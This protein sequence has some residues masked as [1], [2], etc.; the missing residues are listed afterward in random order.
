MSK[1]SISWAGA[2]ATAVLLVGICAVAADWWI[3]LPDD[4]RPTYVGRDTCSQCHQAEYKKWVGS[5]HD[6]AMDLATPE[7]VLGGF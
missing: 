5:H 4:V 3:A 6:L 2:T 1:R 7:T